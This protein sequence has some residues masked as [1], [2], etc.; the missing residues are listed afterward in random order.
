MLTSLNNAVSG[1]RAQMLRM[2]TLGNNIANVNTEAYKKN[3]TNF[4]D[5][6]YRQ[7]QG[8]GLPVGENVM[9]GSGVVVSGTE[10]LF[11][12]GS[13]LSTDRGLDFAIEGPGFFGLDLP[14]GSVGYTRNGNFNLDGEGF[15]V[16]QDGLRIYPYIQLPPEAGTPKVD[17]EGRINIEGEGEFWDDP[18]I[19]EL[20]H[21]PNPSGMEAVGE[22][23]FVET[24]ASGFVSLGFPGEEGLGYIKQGSLEQSNVDLG[25][26]MVEM[27]LAQRSFQ[28]N[29]QTIRT[30]DEMW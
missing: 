2:D 4:K 17:R 18:D 21:V 9:T 16:N 20:F 7:T 1:V 29:T 3:R 25:E 10:K 26:E 30:A 12:Q 15:L 19:I 24:E 5:I 28:L 8:P 22:G 11:M 13:I 6:F 23:V 27:I 14:D